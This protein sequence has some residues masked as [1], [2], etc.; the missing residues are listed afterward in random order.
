MKYQALFV[1]L[2]WW[3]NLKMVSAAN[4]RWRFMSLNIN[5]FLETIITYRFNHLTQIALLSSSVHKPFPA[6]QENLQS[7]H[8]F[9]HTLWKTI[10]QTIRTQIR[11]LILF[12]NVIQSCFL[13]PLS[14]HSGQLCPYM[15]KNNAHIW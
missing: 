14:Y 10:L 4:F 6:I 7:A 1:I 12:A 9:A 15:V 11:L 8:L 5:G 13:L 2:E 3:Q